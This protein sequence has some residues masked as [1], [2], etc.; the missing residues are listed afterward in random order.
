MHS[1]F[2]FLNENLFFMFKNKN[3]INYFDYLGVFTLVIS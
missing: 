1:V 3:I 2:L